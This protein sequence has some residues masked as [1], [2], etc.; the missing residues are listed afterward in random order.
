MCHG[1]KDAEIRIACQRKRKR[2]PGFPCS[3]D[4]VPLRAGR[5]PGVQS[6]QAP[7]E[8]FTWGNV[9]RFS[10]GFWGSSV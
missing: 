8:V 4:G 3:G 1:G 5:F 9:V 7:R 10:G 6:I 2:F